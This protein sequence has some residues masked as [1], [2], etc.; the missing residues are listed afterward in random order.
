MTAVAIFPVL[1]CL[2]GLLVWAMTTPPQ[3][4]AAKISQVAWVCFVVGLAGTTYAL[5]GWVI[6]V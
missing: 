2:L 1:L 4:G 3:G 5:L 6:R